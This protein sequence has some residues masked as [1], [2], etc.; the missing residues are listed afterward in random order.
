MD[1]KIVAIV[2][3]LVIVA[4]LAIGYTILRKR[5]TK[6]LRERFGPEYERSL[7]EHGPGKGESV[8]AEREKRVEK[9]HIRELALDEREHFVTQWREIQSRFVD[10]PKGAV[11]AADELVVRLMNARGYP[12]SDFE[13][14]A[15]DISVDHPRVVE[16][17]RAAHEIALR[18]RT[19][20]AST[21]DLRNAIIYY[22]SLF[23]E[24]LQTRTG[25]ETR[26]VA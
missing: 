2:V 11:G 18:H 25:G 24:L 19:G 14:R 4:I 3:V 7:R 1:P 6:A 8:L 17:Y 26:E 23:N 5:R 10:D 16:N 12:M 9:F 21:E 20:Q 13:Q 15:A 22:R